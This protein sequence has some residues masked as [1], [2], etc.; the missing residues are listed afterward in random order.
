M[1][2]F[3]AAVSEKLQ[4][5]NRDKSKLLAFLEVLAHQELHIWM[6]TNGFLIKSSSTN[7]KLLIQDLIEKNKPVVAESLN[8]EI[9]Q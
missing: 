3:K 7:V 4:F 8:I 9:Y 2:N 6:K 5:E 1:E